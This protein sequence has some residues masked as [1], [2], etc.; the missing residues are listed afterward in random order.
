MQGVWKNKSDMSC[1]VL[2]CICACQGIWWN[3][4]MRFEVA[5]GVHNMLCEVRALGTFYEFVPAS[6]N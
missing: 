1:A 5:A 2:A 3:G 4:G 6:S